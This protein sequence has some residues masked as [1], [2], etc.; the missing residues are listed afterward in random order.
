MSLNFDVF[1]AFNAN[2]VLGRNNTLGQSATPGAYAASQ[3]QQADGSY[4]SLWVP[5]NILQPR[6]ARL[7]VTF[8]F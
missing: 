1:N 4:N 6:F 8:D 3:Q 2:P 7:S 5:T